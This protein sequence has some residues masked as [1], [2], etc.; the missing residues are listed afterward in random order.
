[1]SKTTEQNGRLCNQI[2]RNLAISLIAEKQNLYVDYANYKLI[3]ELGINLFIGEHKFKN[4][5]IINN[6]NFFNTLNLQENTLK[7]NIDGNSSYFQTKEIT[8]FLY[9]YLHKN[10][11][12]IINANPL[13]DDYEN[14][15]DCFIHIRLGDVADKNPGLNY[16]LEALSKI[17]FTNLFIASDDIKHHIV[18]D[19]CN[20]YPSAIIINGDEKKTIQTGSTKKYI[21]LSHGSFSAIIG[22][23]GFFSTIYYPKYNPK[24]IW[25]GD[26]FSI[27]NWICI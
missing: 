5:K 7:S 20:K 10:K 15:N 8:N 14:N 1:M 23:L 24:K 11:E 27:P 3:K 17:E 26:M 4:S 13:K 12:S 21:I 16:Y 22:Y 19:I 2:I 18:K 25:Y 6:D 9:S